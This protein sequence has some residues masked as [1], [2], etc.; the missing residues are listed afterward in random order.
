MGPAP[1]TSSRGASSPPRGGKPVVAVPT[2]RAEEAEKEAP[3]DLR[4]VLLATVAW[5][6]A[7]GGFLLPR[8]VSLAVLGAVLLALLH[9]NRRGRPVLVLAACL[10]AAT[11]VACSAILRAQ[12]NDQNPVAQL[13]QE[14]AFVSAT[15]RVTSDPVLEQGRYEPYVLVHAQVHEVTG[16]GA[17]HRTS[18]PVLVI[19]GPAWTETEL[20]ATVVVEGRLAEAEGDD[21]AA[22]V[23]TSR[24]PA[25]VA[26]PGW[27]FGAAARIRAGI[28]AAVAPAGLE[29]RTLIPALVVGDDQG[30]PE[31]VVEDF[32]V[33]GLTHLSAVSGT[34][35]TLVVGFVLILARWAGVRARGLIVV[36]ALGV[37]GFVLLAR[38][39]P[40]VVRAAAMGSV[41]L[42]GMGSN[43]REKGTR[44]LG[45]A[46]LVLLLFDPWLALSLGFVLS[47]LATAGIL[48]LAPPWR[49][50]LR[51][52]LPRWMAEAIAVPLA[53]QLVC[54]PVV[55]AISGQVSLVAVVANMLVAPAVGPATVL[56]LVGGLLVLVVE[57]VGLVCGRL[58]GW[59]GWWI[60]SVAEHSAELP[61]AA[62]AWSA[63][64]AAIIALSLLC[65]AVASVMPQLLRRR[66]WSLGAAA[67]M[68]LTI[69]RPLPTMGWPPPG[70]VMV[71]CDVGQ[72][73][74]LVLNAGDGSAVLVDTGPDPEAMAHC[75]DRL[76]VERLPFVVLTHFHADHVDGLPAVLEEHHV[77]EIDVTALQEPASG[78]ASVHRWA[79]AERVPVRVPAYGEVQQVGALTWQVIGPGQQVPGGGHGEE[80]SPANNASLV[81]LVVTRGIRILLTGDMEP[82]A[83]EQLEGA[84]PAL[85]ADVVKV[86]HHGSRYQDPGFLSGLGARLAVI[87]VG[88]DNDYG[89]PSPNT[90]ALLR[91][92]GMLVRR[93]D[94]SGDLAVVVRGGRMRVI[95]SGG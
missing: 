11:A 37:A 80:G 63:T 31:Q 3:P 13:A 89:H 72:G 32:Q 94:R 27:L 26:E 20:G 25:V 50:A 53:A 70:W 54:T 68:V 61:T 52:W 35:L 60:V 65:V 10:A 47:A 7:L 21:L 73:D 1:A 87:S 69:V 41:A 74:G 55:A 23:S 2:D 49:D 45:V 42:I 46:L 8:W 57:P 51:R 34:N 17:A 29:E 15:V 82:E 43:G 75:L 90:V 91:R 77:G 14:R 16:R 64:A 30:M 5:A 81:L 33:S 44:A 95:T 86:P 93:T 71:A 38:T 92:A 58:A 56:G 62:V 66:W 22:V 88:E 12:A 6:G 19:A 85:R 9:R 84:L 36:G 78:A 18:V 67:L 59:C 83:Q 76:D 4:M 39:E 24:P 48:F 79:S 40:S 28:R